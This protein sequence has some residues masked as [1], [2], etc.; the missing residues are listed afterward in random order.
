MV[1]RVAKAASAL[2]FGGTFLIP[3]GAFAAIDKILGGDVALQKP[4]FLMAA[5]SSMA[6]VPILL[7]MITSFVK[8]IVVLNILRQGLGMQQTPP[9]MVLTAIAFMMTAFV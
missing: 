7:V 5:L 1:G 2:A 9:T 6:L 3:A 4:L 8:M